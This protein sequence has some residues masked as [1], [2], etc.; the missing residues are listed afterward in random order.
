MSSLDQSHG[1]SDRYGNGVEAI[2]QG[3]SVS[4]LFRAIS[5][6]QYSTCQKLFDILPGLIELFFVRYS[7]L[8]ISEWLVS[9]LAAYISV[10]LCIED[11]Q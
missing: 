2:H 1:R 5:R 10:S 4:Q 6:L 9:T 11:A 7:A 3:V 8:V